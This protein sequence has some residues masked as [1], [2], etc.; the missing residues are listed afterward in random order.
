MVRIERNTL[1]FAE[2]IFSPACFVVVVFVVIATVLVHV[3]VIRSSLIDW[4]GL[5]DSSLSKYVTTTHL[6][7]TPFPP[8]PSLPPP[9]SLRL[10]LPLISP[11]HPFNNSSH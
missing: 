11:R 7:C 3:L 6:E 4:I 5:N 8:P 9:S 2:Q 10:Y 1:T